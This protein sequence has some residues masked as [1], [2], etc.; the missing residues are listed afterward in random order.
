MRRYNEAVKAAVRWRISPSQRQ[1]V[2][3]IAEELGIPVVT[4][5]NSRNTWRMQGEVMLAS[6]RESEG[7]N[8]AEQFRVVL[9]TTGLS[10]TE[11]GAY[12][13]ER[14]RIPDQVARWR[15]AA[16]EANAKPVLTIGDQKALESLRAQHQREIKALMKELQRKEETTAEAAALLMLPHT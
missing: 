8:A 12:C 16:N 7:W 2:A 9:K 11:L 4:L 1:R 15:Q 14:G 10:D 3:R 5:Y 6:E 13:R